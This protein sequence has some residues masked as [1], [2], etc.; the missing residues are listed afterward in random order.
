MAHILQTDYSLLS[1]LLFMGSNLVRSHS[2]LKY[3][4]RLRSLLS[5]LQ[6]NLKR[7]II[8]SHFTGYQNPADFI[9][10]VLKYGLK[11]F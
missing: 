4:I 5:V 8:F 6:G 9:A 11:K 3:G 1:T 7:S 10:L 2:L